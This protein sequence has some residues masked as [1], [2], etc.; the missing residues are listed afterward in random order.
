MLFRVH[1]DSLWMG[2]ETNHDQE[3]NAVNGGSWAKQWKSRWQ[4][5]HILRQQLHSWHLASNNRDIQWW[6]PQAR[7]WNPNLHVEKW[8]Q[9]TGR[10]PSIQGNGWQWETNWAD[11]Q[12]IISDS[13]S[14]T[15][16]VLLNYHVGGGLGHPSWAQR[17]QSR[18]Y[19]ALVSACYRWSR[20][21]EHTGH[22]WSIRFNT[23]H[24]N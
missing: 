19:H 6:F 15:S 21:R 3:S 8:A 1:L 23:D 10:A 16:H 14:K 11:D 17:P 22:T 20:N 9:F 12:H 13:E 4:S 7:S 2:W 24:I 5:Q 18:A